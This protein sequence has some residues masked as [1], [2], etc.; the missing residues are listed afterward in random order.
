M[1]KYCFTIIGT[2]HCS[3]SS[4][5]IS[6]TLDGLNVKIQH[7]LDFLKCKLNRNSSKLVLIKQNKTSIVTQS[8]THRNLAAVGAGVKDFYVAEVEDGGQYGEET[9]GETEDIS[10][11]T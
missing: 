2:S 11:C 10:K 1:A 6:G 8:E 5:T 4:G 9:P 7:G 3:N